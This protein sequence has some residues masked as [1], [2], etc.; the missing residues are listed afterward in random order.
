MSA[1]ITKAELVAMG[2]APDARFA[3]FYPDGTLYFVISSPRF[4]FEGE[5]DYWYNRGYSLKK[6]VDE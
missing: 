6:V 5:R 4:D 3:C 1:T 2:G